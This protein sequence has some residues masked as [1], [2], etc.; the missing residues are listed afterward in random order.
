MSINIYREHVIVVPEDEADRQLANGFEQHHSVRHRTIQIMP[1]A[2]GWPALFDLFRKEYAS[3]VRKYP[4]AHI[5][6]I[7]DFDDDIESRLRQYDRVLSEFPDRAV[8]EN[9]VY[10]LGATKD[11]EQLS[12]HLKLT[13]TQIGLQLAEECERGEFDLWNH[14]LL[15][16]NCD[17]RQPM[18]AVRDT[19]FGR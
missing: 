14:E 1:I 8:W 13:K 18:V 3:Y 11:P 6:L 4:K 16:H 17:T 15:A 7:V 9:R 2:G 12:S 19:L 5:V 10:L